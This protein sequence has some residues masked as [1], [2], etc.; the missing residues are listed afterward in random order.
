MRLNNIVEKYQMHGE[1]NLSLSRQSEEAPELVEFIVSNI[2]LMPRHMGQLSLWAQ[3]HKNFSIRTDMVWMTKWLRVLIPF[4][5]LY[6]KLFSDVDGFFTLDISSNITLD[7]NLMITIKGKNIL[8]EKY[9]GFVYPNLDY[10]MPY[11]P[12]MGRN[13]TIGLSYMFN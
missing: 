2:Q 8:N 7:D 1:L 12:Q 9:S 6:S 3:P 4:E 5:S 13:F 11:S 10:S